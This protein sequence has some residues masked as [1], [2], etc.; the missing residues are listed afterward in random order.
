MTLQL[1]ETF[2]NAISWTVI[3]SIWQ[4]SLLALCLSIA[5]VYIPAKKSSLRY[6]L[7]LLTMGLGFIAGVITFMIY[8]FDTGTAIAGSEIL[9]TLEN[10]EVIPT[11]AGLTERWSL[12]IEDYSGLITQFWIV[13]VIIRRGMQSLCLL[14]LTSLEKGLFGIPMGN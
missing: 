9:V 8:Y 10:T 1:S 5:N 4:I 12:L 3:H 11:S 6:N 7:G 2:I 14:F 13:G